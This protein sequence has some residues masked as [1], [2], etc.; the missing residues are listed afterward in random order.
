MIKLGPMKV[1]IRK[2][3]SC[4]SHIEWGDTFVGY[5]PG[6]EQWEALQRAKR[7]NEIRDRIT[8]LLFSEVHSPEYWARILDAP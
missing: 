6:L 4:Q 2:P 8:Q 7:T 3:R 5:W 1:G